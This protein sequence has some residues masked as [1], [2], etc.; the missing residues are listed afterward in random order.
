MLDEFE[1]S[2]FR[3]F[4]NKMGVPQGFT[5]GPLLFLLYVNYLV[6]CMYSISV[7]LHLFC[8]QMTFV[9]VLVLLEH[10]KLIDEINTEPNKV[11]Q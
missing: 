3:T 10:T 5:L 8:L 4:P 6:N 9:L 7:M 2:D 1:Y 11:Y